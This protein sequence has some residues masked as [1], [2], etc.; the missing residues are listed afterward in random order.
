MSLFIFVSVLLCLAQ[1]AFQIF[2]AV[3]GNDFI[4]K[5]EFLE[6]LLRHVGLVRL[7]E[8]DALSITQWLAPEVISFVGSIIIFIVLRK[9]SSLIVENLN[10]VGDGGDSAPT[11]MQ[12]ILPEYEQEFTLEKWK[13]LMRAGKIISLLVLCATGALQ[14]SALSVVYYFVFLGAATWWGCNKQLEK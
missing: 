3:V 4:E 14:P 9:S 12:P 7:D 5:C 13:V 11:S 10:G 2:L 8:L 1:S 6:I